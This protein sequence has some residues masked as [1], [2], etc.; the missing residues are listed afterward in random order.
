MSQVLVTNP[1]HLLLPRT[2]FPACKQRALRRLLVQGRLAQSRCV[3]AP[4]LSYA[5]LSQSCGSGKALG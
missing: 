4:S 1:G 3:D 2:L 5:C